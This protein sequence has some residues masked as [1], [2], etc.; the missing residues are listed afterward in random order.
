MCANN[1][2][3]CSA[4]AADS[5]VSPLQAQILALR[6]IEEPEQVHAFIH[7]RLKDLPDPFLLPDMQVAVERLSA[8]IRNREPVAIHGDYDVDGISATA[9]VYTALQY[10]GAEVRYHIPLRLQDGYGLSSVALRTDAA[11]GVRVVVSVDCGIS[12]LD[13]AR[14]AAELGLDLIITDHHQPGSELPVAH[15][16]I[17][18]WLEASQYPY[19]PL[20]GVGV[21]FML[22]VALQAHL[23]RNNLL[24]NAPFDVRTLLD[25]VTLGTIADL[26]P[27]TGVN[28]ML[29]R[30]GLPLL[31]GGL[32][33]RSFEPEQGGR[34]EQ[35]DRRVRRVQAGAK[36]ER[37]GSA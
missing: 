8:A 7:A 31:Q 32:S 35:R 25:L 27:L 21:A 20:C 15:A 26:V 13:E 1:I 2:E 9:L 4:A 33:S 34:T 37:G 16:C 36:I 19:V 18:P 17:N 28:R 22:V 23:R 14:V 3:P 24:P 29:V 10:F 30:T 5:G 11:D 6:G 12:A